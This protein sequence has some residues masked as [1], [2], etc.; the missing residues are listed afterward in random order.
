MKD[1]HDEEEKKKAAEE[2]KEADDD[3]EGMDD[4][5]EVSVEWMSRINS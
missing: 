5:D 4:I 2:A 1:A 3:D